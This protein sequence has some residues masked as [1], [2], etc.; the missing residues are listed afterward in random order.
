M[1]MRE[2][3]SPREPSLCL[4][5]LFCVNRGMRNSHISL[6][7][8]WSW[9]EA[10][11]YTSKQLFRW[12]HLRGVEH[13]VKIDR[14]SLI[15][16]ILHAQPVD[17]KYRQ[18]TQSG[19][20]WSKDSLTDGAYLLARAKS[21]SLPSIGTWNAS[22]MQRC[23]F[24]RVAMF[25]VGVTC[26]WRR[27]WERPR[28]HYTASRPRSHYTASN[29]IIMPSSFIILQETYGVTYYCL[30][31]PRH[32]YEEPHLSRARRCLVNAVGKETSSYADGILTKGIIIP[33]IFFFFF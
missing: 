28:S 15:Q 25:V 3:F 22:I 24:M 13:N 19:T 29:I 30:M 33:M 16:T 21:P 4:V 5:A 26:G 2:A 9:H 11:R 10:L 12:S 31:L 14:P 18:V 23:A 8:I 27:T 6:R 20:T 32:C 7:A 1:K 17:I